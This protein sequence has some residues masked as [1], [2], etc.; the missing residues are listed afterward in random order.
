MVK[1]AE[2]HLEF[3]TNISKYI[4]KG[5]YIGLFTGIRKH[6]PIV[7]SIYRG[8]NGMMTITEQNSETP[9]VQQYQ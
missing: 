9:Q 6:K 7:S 2:C 1:E 5:R 4:Y 3:I 8:S